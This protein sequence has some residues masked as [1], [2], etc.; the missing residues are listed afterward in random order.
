MINYEFLAFT[1][2]VSLL[3]FWQINNPQ[4][5]AAMTES[6]L[7]IFSQLTELCSLRCLCVCLLVTVVVTY[8]HPHLCIAWLPQVCL[9]LIYFVF[10]VCVNAASRR[11]T[12]T[13]PG[14][15]T[16][17]EKATRNTL[18]SSQW[19]FNSKTNIRIHLEIFIITPSFIIMLT[20]ILALGSNVII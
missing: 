9:W 16:V 12:I 2:V 11:W 18:S 13:A 5:A 17:S 1:W 7:F 3:Q 6:S 15:I 19:V 4:S 14:W 20:L 10:T 8:Q